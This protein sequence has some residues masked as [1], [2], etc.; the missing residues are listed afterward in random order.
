M[1]QELFLLWPEQAYKDQKMVI[2]LSRPLTRLWVWPLTRPEIYTLRILATT[3]SESF[4]LCKRKPLNAR[5]SLYVCSA[6]GGFRGTLI[7]GVVV[8][9]LYFHIVLSFNP[10]T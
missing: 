6:P 5:Q 3:R 9:S 1:L 4:L 10:L 2:R 8:K 7:K